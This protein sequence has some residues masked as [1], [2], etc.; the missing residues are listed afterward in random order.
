MIKK[1]N[2]VF[3]ALLSIKWQYLLFNF[4][5]VL[6]KKHGSIILG[7]KVKFFGCKIIIKDSAILSIGDNSRLCGCRIQLEPNSNMQVGKSCC[8]CNQSII[9]GQIIVG[10]NNLFNEKTALFLVMNTSKLVIGNNNRINA[11]ITC[12]FKGG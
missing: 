10:D 7:R 3:K 6:C 12:R 11:D 1:L 5:L 4:S 2:K 8:L 9:D